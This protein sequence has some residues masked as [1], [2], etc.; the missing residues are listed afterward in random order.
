MKISIKLK[1]TQLVSLVNL[2]ET[3]INTEECTTRMDAIIMILMVKFY[4]DL[5]KKTVMLEPRKYNISVGPEVAMAFIEFFSCIP[6]DRYSHGGNQVDSLI[7]QFD[8]QTAQ[9]F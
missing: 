3:T 2:L 1:H 9:F 4:T 8:K 7:A 6:F 5:K